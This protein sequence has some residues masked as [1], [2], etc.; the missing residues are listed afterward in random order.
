M[1][2]SFEYQPVYDCVLWSQMCEITEESDSSL[3][4]TMDLSIVSREG[5]Y[6]L[7]YTEHLDGQLTPLFTATGL[8]DCVYDGIHPLRTPAPSGY[9]AVMRDGKWG[10]LRVFFHDDSNPVPGIKMLLL[11]EYDGITPSS[12]GSALVLYCGRSSFCYNLLSGHLSGAYD[13]LWL[14]NRFLF[15][16]TDTGVCVTDMQT[17]RLI[18]SVP[19]SHSIAYICSYTNGYV[20]MESPDGIDVTT[21]E[22][23]RESGYLYFYNPENN[24]VSES[25]LYTN[26]SFFVRKN[27]F[28]DSLMGFSY[29]RNGITNICLGQNNVFT[30]EDVHKITKEKAKPITEK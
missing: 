15:G 4:T 1:N 17:D 14:D 5:K 2:C 22:T 10:L 8:C 24:S 29:M 26:V 27:T 21:P 20:F 16:T 3:S 7:I 19:R 25:P 11:R 12:L 13:S 18:L 30:Q 23:P 28:S 6:G 9:F